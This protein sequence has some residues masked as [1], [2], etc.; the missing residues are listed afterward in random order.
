[1]AKV[2]MNGFTVHN[3]EPCP[4]CGAVEYARRE[5]VM[6]T[7][8]MCCNKC[9]YEAEG[10]IMINSPVSLSK[11]RDGFIKVTRAMFNLWNESIAVQIGEKPK[12]VRIINDK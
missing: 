1:M 11:N 5:G 12:R 7:L 3:V 10:A 9:D 2:K 6:R 4:N 8:M